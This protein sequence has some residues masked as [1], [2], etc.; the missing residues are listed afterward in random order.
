MPF[1]S[2]VFQCRDGVQD[3]RAGRA[4]TTI[5]EPKALVPSETSSQAFSLVAWLMLGTTAIASILFL[6]R[7]A[8]RASPWLV[9]ACGLS[10]AGAFLVLVLAGYL[11]PLKRRPKLYM[12]FP[13]ASIGGQSMFLAFV[14]DAVASER[15]GLRRIAFVVNWQI[16]LVA[17][18]VAYLALSLLVRQ[19]RGR[20]EPF[21]EMVCPLVGFWMGVNLLGVELVSRYVR[22]GG[23]R[24]LGFLPNALPHLIMGSLGFWLFV[25]LSRGSTTSPRVVSGRS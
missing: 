5:E 20:W 15:F 17:T 11:G 19:L 25:R 3:C 16:L 22:V 13:A 14:A 18:I 9:I 24:L 8:T 10:A 1:G 6:G 23:D 12:L 4:V 7:N 2:L 21:P